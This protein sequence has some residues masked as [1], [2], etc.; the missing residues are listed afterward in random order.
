MSLKPYF[1][2]IQLTGHMQMDN[3]TPSS[4]ATSLLPQLSAS[5]TNSGSMMKKTATT[6][7]RKLGLKDRKRGKHIPEPVHDESIDIAAGSSLS[8]SNMQTPV[9]QIPTSTSTH[10]FT[11]AQKNDFGGATITNVAGNQI[12]NYDSRPSSGDTKKITADMIASATPAVPIVFKGREELVEQGVNILCQQA[13]RFLAILG[14]GGMGK[15]L[16]ALH[17][18]NSSLVKDK[19]AG[20]GY[21]IPCELFEDA[22]SLVLGLVHVMKL[23]MQE[24]KSRHE[25]LFDHL[26]AAQGDHLFVF[27]NFETPWNHGDSRINVKNLLEKIAQYGKVSLIVTMRGPDGPGD[28][29]WKKLGD[30]SGIPPLLPVPAKEAFKAFVDDNFKS[31][32]D[33]E[34]QLDSLLHQLEYVPLAIRL[35]AQHVKRIPLEELVS[36]WQKDKTSILREGRVP[37]RLTS[38][39]FSIDL[40]LQ[41]FEIE[42]RILNLLSA[43]SFL[44]DGIPLWSQHLS[45]MFHEEKLSFNVSKL[46]ES[47]L[48]YEK[49]QGL[50]MLA[51]VRDH[52]HLNYPIGQ[53]DID[54]LE[55]F[56]AKFLEHLPENTMEAQPLLQ[57][58]INNIEKIVTVQMSS[59]ESKTSH[60]STV[61]TLGRFERFNSVSIS[62][63][64]LLI[65][66]NQDIKNEDEI[67]LKLMRASKLKWMGRFQEAEAQVMSV[68]E[69]LN[70]EENISKSEADILGR[71]FGTLQDIYY[72]QAQYEKAITMNVRAQKYFK[73]SENQW[74]QADSMRLLGNIYYMQSKYKEASEMISEAQ[75]LFQEIRNELGVA[76]CLK[77][78]GDIY[79][80]QGKYVE[81]IEMLLDAQKQFETFGNQ[82]RA[83]ECL[84]SLGSIYRKQEK[85]DKASEMTLKAQI[86]FEENGFKRGVADCLSNLG[87]IYVDQS[88]YDEA[89]KTFSN[90]QRQYQ[91]IGRSVDVARCF[92]CLGRTYWFQ[93]QYEKAK[94]A[95]TEALE[96]FKGFSGEKYY[97]GYTLLNFGYLLFDM[98]E[99]AEARKKYEEARDI[100]D[101]HGEL[102]K[103]VDYCSRA[104]AKL[105]EVEAAGSISE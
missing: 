86:Q 43:I 30:K 6:A 26:G 17:I 16:L 83:A 2:I 85:Y 96:L 95:F 31:T 75:Q 73:Q 51:P 72:A 90:A 97:V 20:R 70:E 53:D 41:I 68:K 89:V 38:V 65:Q 1:F 59:G 60:I 45:Q 94:E 104:L 105:D 62:L 64:A 8:S 19:F 101:S 58:H 88:Q 87:Y 69:G 32:N 77:R 27:D 63:I 5:D 57:I 28:I 33:S 9:E 4:S 21:F 36:M 14:A 34:S 49:N 7:L 22:E 10:F 37:G 56:Y 40:S 29:S 80:M 48:I 3:F 91:S 74:A 47:S 12:V 23:T 66:T 18:M 39:S 54:Q 55:E 61:N 76:E 44:P 15:T 25:V 100:F 81:A 71:C 84:W 50:K 92:E 99:F 78:L 98:E 46:L 42:G 24:N 79:R 13:L 82:L 102:E 52:I 35:S 103:E 93:G 67:D 11:G